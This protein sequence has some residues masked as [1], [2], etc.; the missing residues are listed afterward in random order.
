M[1]QSCETAT[2]PPLAPD[3]F[4]LK[5]PSF[6]ALWSN[7]LSPAWDTFWPRALPLNYLVF[8]HQGVLFCS[9]FLG[10]GQIGNWVGVSPLGSFSMRLVV[11]CL[12]VGFLGSGLS[13]YLS[14]QRYNTSIREAFPLKLGHNGLSLWSRLISKPTTRKTVKIQSL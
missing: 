8:L 2:I 12:F 7:P 14:P 3:P 4:L 6:Q 11:L 10:A 5:T 9:W 13:G 1:N